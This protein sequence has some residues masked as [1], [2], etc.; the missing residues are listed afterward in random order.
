MQANPEKFQAI[1]VGKRT[2][3]MSNHQVIIISYAS[4]GRNHIAMMSNNSRVILRCIYWTIGGI[5]VE[6]AEVLMKLVE[7]WRNIGGI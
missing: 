2:L 7:Y 1:G 6:P 5:L 3:L 4:K